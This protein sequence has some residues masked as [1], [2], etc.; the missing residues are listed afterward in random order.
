MVVDGS[1]PLAWECRD[2]RF[3]CPSSSRCRSYC[4]R[5]HGAACTYREPLV[6]GQ[7]LSLA[8]YGGAYVLNPGEP[9]TRQATLMAA[10]G[11]ARVI[12][13]DY[14]TSSEAPYPAALDDCV[15]VYRELLK[16][17]QAQN[18][19]VFGTST[20]GG[21]TMALVLRAKQDGFA[22][23]AAIAPGSPWADLTKTGDIF[24]SHNLVDNFQSWPDA[25]R[26]R[27]SRNGDRHQH[28]DYFSGGRRH[29]QRRHPGR[30]HLGQWRLCTVVG[31]CVE[32]E[33]AGPWLCCRRH[34]AGRPLRR[35]R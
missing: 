18:I 9:G 20:G 10:F 25:R 24:Y 19:A 11:Q 31:W 29:D 32:M 21:L 17:V 4:S 6:R 12:S 7:R 13:V 22:L 3:T 28:A 33:C 15:A 8:H 35:D 5:L 23:P 16:T 14:R 26:R 27:F 2:D 1:Y 34:L 30:N